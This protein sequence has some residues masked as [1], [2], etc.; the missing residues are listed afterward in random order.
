MTEWKEYKLG[1]LIDII[2]GGTP[3]TSIAEYWNGDIPWL[4]VVDF[5]N[6]KKYVY[7]TEK[8]ITKSGL[9]NSSTKLLEKG[10][11]I[12]SARGTVGVLAVLGR[13]MAFNQSCYGIRAKQNLT[14]Q[15]YLYYLLKYSINNLILISHGGV[16]DTITRESFYNINCQLP[17]LPEQTEIAGVL[18][19][20]DDKIDLLLSQNKTLEQLAET[21]YRQ[22]FIEE[23][24]ESWEKDVLGNLFDIG[25]GRTPPRKEQH[26][27]TTNPNDYKWIS[28]KD[29]GISGIYIDSVS[30]YLTKEA[31]ATYNVPIIP[32]N[33]LILSFK[34][35]IGRVA[36]TTSEML[37]NEAIA[38]FKLKKNC[39]LFSEF[40]YL[41]LKSFQ[42]G[43]LGSTSSIAE[44]I[45]S[46]N[47]KDIEI[48]V[49]SKDILI[50][51]KN[52]II[53]YFQKIKANQAQ[54]RT[55]TQMRDTLL[56]KLMS[57]EVSVK[58]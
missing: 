30:E 32:T 55:L 42:Y 3:K 58:Y 39:N 37:S 8:K 57:G 34:L 28:I 43:S 18:S 56:P 31:V 47:I 21:L 54:I 7:E 51:F 14:Y 2:G 6:G 13:I 25:I 20:L 16:F 11:I 1:N 22:W 40:L 26:W 44:A 9:E 12:I 48:S 41:F 52:R 4:S 33:T 23:A 53:P 19:S 24:D 27:F 38:H 35:T 36:I 5:N 29:M 50:N 17:P 15:E 49:P 10:D 45:N 46:R